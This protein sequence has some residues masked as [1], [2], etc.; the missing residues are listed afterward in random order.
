MSTR[1]TQLAKS[2]H[3]I[4][5]LRN[6]A[7]H[8]VEQSGGKLQ[9]VHAVSQACEILGLKDLPD[10]YGLREIAAEQLNAQRSKG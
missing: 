10:T 9:T 6:L 5:V 2:L 8:L 7:A 4:S 1:G 3:T